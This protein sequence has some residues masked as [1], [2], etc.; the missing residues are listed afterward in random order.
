LGTW[1]AAAIGGEQ[2][3]GAVFV[4]LDQQL[5]AAVDDIALFKAGG[6]RPVE[7]V[8]LDHLVALAVDRG[9]GPGRFAAEAQDEITQ[10]H[11]QRAE[12]HRLLRPQVAVGQQSADQRGEV[13]QR[14]EPAVQP[15]GGAVAEQ[16]M[17]GQVQRQQRAHAVVAET[18]PH[19]GGEQAGQL[20]RV[21]EPAG[22]GSTLRSSRHG[23]LL[24][25]YIHQENRSPSR[26]PSRPARQRHERAVYAGK[27]AAKWGLERN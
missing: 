8:L 1:R 2:R 20:S 11:H 15:V 26:V 3:D 7:A 16:E 6:G 25:R 19:L 24:R 9:V 12:L 22:V 13:D 23:G 14:G 10:R 5:A 27:L 18:F 21:T 17:L 4:A